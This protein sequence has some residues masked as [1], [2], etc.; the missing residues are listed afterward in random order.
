MTENKISHYIWPGQVHFGFGAVDRVGDEAR[1]LAVTAASTSRSAGAFLI[2]DPGVASAGLLEPILAALE[3]AGVAVIVHAEAEANPSIESVYATTAVF[4]DSGAQIIIGV[5]G[6]SPLDT[7][8]AVKLQAGGPVDA[9]IWQYAALAGEEQ[10]PYPPPSAMPPYIAIPT[11]AG[12]GAEVTPWGVLTH[13][14]KHIKFG[15]GDASTVPE[16]ALIDPG[17]TLTMP[18]HLTAATGM[19][20]LS[21]LIEAYVSTNHNPILDPMILYGIELVGRSLRTA[22]AHG[23][24]RQARSD[25]S[26]ASMIGGIAISSKWCGA[27]HS[28]AHPLSSLAGVHHGLACGMMLPS[29]MTYSLAGAPERYTAVAQALMPGSVAGAAAAVHD[30]LTDIGLPT[31]LRDAG[32]AEA[33]IPPLAKAAY[34]DLNWWTNPRQVSETVMADLYRQA[35]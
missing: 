3:E 2:T 23:D 28:L 15:V 19:D 33:L 4:R 26:Q 31:R 9:S 17:L 8:K 35:W 29:Q 10:R 30:L 20:V 7:A 32:V 14:E 22:V 1:R 18:A 5:G 13:T 16:V 11:T 34:I 6:G 24:N 25:M 12:T 21:H 27:C